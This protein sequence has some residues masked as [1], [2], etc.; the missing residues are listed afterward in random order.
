MKHR[1]LQMQ[2][3]CH[4]GFHFELLPSK[5]VAAGR[6]VRGLH[7][8]VSKGHSA[9]QI[10]GFLSQGMFQGFMEQ[11]SGKAA[12]WFVVLSENCSF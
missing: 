6:I 4:S 12:V 8:F 5:F 1:A 2:S 9:C 3:H 10:L 11:G 7:K